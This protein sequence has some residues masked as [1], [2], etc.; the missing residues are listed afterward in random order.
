MDE[1]EKAAMDMRI[2][3]DQCIDEMT[4]PDS[5]SEYLD[6]IVRCPSQPYENQLLIWKQYPNASEVAGIARWKGE[7]RWIREETRPIWILL[8]YIRYRSGSGK[9]YRRDDGLI[10]LDE[11]QR[12]LYEKEPEYDT[13]YVPAAV[14]DISQTEGGKVPEVRDRPPERIEEALRSL[15]ITISEERTDALPREL[16]DGY[17]ADS[18][19]HIARNLRDAGN[20]YYTVLL[21]LFANWVIANMREPGSTEE[22]PQHGD[23]I[24]VVCAYCLQCWYFSKGTEVRPAIV[25]AKL[26]SFSHGERRDIL[27]LTSRYF[28][29]MLQYLTKT[30][31]GFTD[32][33]VINGLLDTG[34][35]TDISALF[36]RVLR[37]AELDEEVSHSISGLLDKLIC[38]DRE[39]TAELYRKKLIDKVI[40]SSPP[41]IIPQ[42]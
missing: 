39:F 19:F 21:R 3:A 29:R 11:Q 15:S 23:I 31:L 40:L 38:A 14:F 16:P 12:V 20:R 18:T 35:M 6:L 5:I 8:P 24:A 13:G 17:A 27:R 7:G 26:K 42:L 9:P 1:R 10:L 4:K 33:A 37:E 32:T 25:A 34:N 22:S 2:L 30:E 36:E 28:Y 41:V